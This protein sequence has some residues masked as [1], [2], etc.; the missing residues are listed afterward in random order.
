MLAADLFSCGLFVES[1]FCFVFVSTY[2]VKFL[3][4]YMSIP[5]GHFS[6]FQMP[7]VSWSARVSSLAWFLFVRSK[8]IECDRHRCAMPEWDVYAMCVCVCNMKCD[9]LLQS[10]ALFAK[11]FGFILLGWNSCKL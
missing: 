1:V 10:E 2:T 3:L 11:V 9:P 7:V 4:V 8:Q 6:L 5:M